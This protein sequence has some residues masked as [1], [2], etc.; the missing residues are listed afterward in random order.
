M[1]IKV[2]FDYGGWIARYPEFALVNEPTANAYFAEAQIYHDNSGSPY[3][4]TDATVQLALL[5]M[6]TAHIAQRYAII[7]GV[8]P[9]PLVGRISNASEGSVSVGVEGFN[10]NAPGSQAWFLQTKYGADY[11]FATTAYR[12]MHYVTG[13]RRIFDPI[14]PPTIV[15]P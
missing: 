13:P 12:T 5:N 4:P 2:S 6:M 1:G 14:F 7:A 11:W 8:A 9:S 3:G 10:A 15:V